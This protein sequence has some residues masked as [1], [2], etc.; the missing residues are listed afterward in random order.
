MDK[1]KYFRRCMYILCLI[2]ILIIC[3]TIYANWKIPHETRSSIYDSIDSVPTSKAAL[4]LGSSKYLKNGMLNPYFKY[5]M[6]ATVDL[7]N[8][9]KI[10]AIVVSGD[11]SRESYNEPQD[12]KDYLVQA[13]IPDSIVY[14]DYAGFRTL[15]SV[16][17]MSEIFGQNEF[18]IVSQKF[19][20]ERAV[21]LAK[22]YGYITYGYNANDLNVNRFSI[23][24]IIRE[25]FAR[26]KVFIDLFLNKKPKFLG[27]KIEIK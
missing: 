1:K 18:I 2:F 4:V 16:V 6:D 5:R 12:M 15:D 21:Y 10:K 19:H 11:N 25:K 13:G 7:Y 3:F 8:S 24:T 26:V 14:M 17:R 20:N 27:E 9:G 22:N 23:K